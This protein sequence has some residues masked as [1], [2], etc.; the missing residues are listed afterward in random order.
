MATVEA[1][2]EFRSAQRGLVDLAVAELADF[3]ATLNP[4]DAVATSRALQAFLPAL[5]DEYGD[6][7]ASVAADF[8]EGLREE[9]GVKKRFKTLLAD[10]VPGEAIQANVRYNLTPLFGK[11]DPDQALSN[12]HLV[13]DKAVKASG[14]ETVALNVERDPAQAR[15][16]RVPTGGHTCDFCLMLASRGAVYLNSKAAGESRDYHGHCDCSAIPIWTEDDLPPGYDPDALYKEFKERQRAQ[17][18]KK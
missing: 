18:K 14:R 11:S 15:Y 17:S 4:E 2:N 16:A 6:M 13:T 10:P 7:A 8:Y 5:I 12:L 1:L 9:A 3:W